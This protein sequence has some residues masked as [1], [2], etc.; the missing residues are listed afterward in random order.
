MQGTAQASQPPQRQR[1]RPWSPQ[2]QCRTGRAVLLGDRARQDN[3][4]D[5]RGAN[6]EVWGRESGVWAVEALLSQ[7]CTSPGHKR[8]RSSHPPLRSANGCM[9]LAHTTMHT[10]KLGCSVYCQR[11]V[12]IPSLRSHCSPVF[13]CFAPACLGCSK[14]ATGTLWRIETTDRFGASICESASPLEANPRRL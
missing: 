8:H 12:E 6:V 10:I 14:L 5:R 7:R 1:G 3:V 11:L 9:Q 13:P 2:A 4:V